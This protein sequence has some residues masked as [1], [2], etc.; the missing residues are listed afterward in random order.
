V[1]AN[2]NCRSASGRSGASKIA[3]RLAPTCFRMATLGTYALA[4]GARWNWH[5]CHGTPESRGPQRL[6]QPGM[7]VA[8]DP[9]HAMKPMGLE[10]G[11]ELPPGDLGLRERDAHPE[12]RAAAFGVDA[13][14]HEHCTREDR[15]AV[16]DL[17]G[18]GIPDQVRHLAEGPVLPCLQLG[19]EGGG[20]PA[21]LGTADLQA[22][23]L[24]GDG[25][26]LAGRDPVNIPL[27]HGSFNAR[28]LRTP[29]SRAEGEKSMP[30][31][32]GTSTVSGPIRVRRVLGLKPWA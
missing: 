28:S 8:D 6:L 9:P 19:I 12:D 27:G 10:A 3:R 16:A 30:R 23:E 1:T 31:A 20:G 26:H 7:A 11:E 5:R 14:G 15:A 24:L 2:S 17:L 13:D 32:W 18:A 22:A 4:F 29:F 21:D 25:G